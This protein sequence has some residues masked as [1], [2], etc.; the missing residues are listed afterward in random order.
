MRR[1][2]AA[3]LVWGAASVAQGHVRP[4]A[5]TAASQRA[6]G[7]LVLGAT[8][9]LAFR[10]G[11]EWS[12]GCAAAFA[13][14]ADMEDAQVALDGA[15]TIVLG[16]RGGLYESSDGCTFTQPEGP[17][18]DGW[19]IDVVPD[20]SGGVY[21]ALSRVFGQDQLYH[22]GRGEPWV[23]LGDPLDTLLLAQ[24]HASGRDLWRLVARPLTADA[25]R[26]LFLERSTDGLAFE[27]WEIA[28]E[29]TEVG[30]TILAA[31][32]GEAHL[33][34]RH[35]DG[36]TVPQRLLRFDVASATFELVHRAPLLDAGAW[37][38]EGLWVIGRLGGLDL[39]VDGRSFEP[40][41]DVAGRCLATIDGALAACLDPERDGM[42]LAWVT[43]EELTPIVRLEAFDSLRECPP[44]SE[45]ALICPDFREAL[46]EDV[47]VPVDGVPPPGAPTGGCGCTLLTRERAPRMEGALALVWL[48]SQRR[49]RR[50][51]KA[52]AAPTRAKP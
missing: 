23:A 45:G 12:L 2:G 11:G 19:V 21:A 27:R 33:A 49:R 31:R 30:A 46:A 48:W 26:R 25:P 35:L 28:L 17:L 34:L 50:P 15:G 29:G 14:D 32:G 9:G 47:G 52:R 40:V 13:V 43:R 1:L 7:S 4:A 41:H 24:L 42:A 22:R 36:D 39:S 51:K 10:D 38:D 5:L 6:D 16:T 8:W 3:L 18:A 44:E 37:T 20:G